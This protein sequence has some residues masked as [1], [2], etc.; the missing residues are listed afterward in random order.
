MKKNAIITA[1]CAILGTLG[2]LEGCGQK[3]NELMNYIDNW[4]G[5]ADPSNCRPPE[6][7]LE[8]TAQFA[9]QPVNE[10]CIVLL[11]DSI[12]DFGEWDK[13]LPGRN[14]LNRGIAGDQIEGMILRLDEIVRHNP[15]KIYLLAGTNNFV[16]H[17]AATSA[18]VL[19]VY[20]KMVALLRSKM[21]C[22]AI[23]LESILPQNPVSSDWTDHYNADVAAMNLCI[24]DLAEKYGC[25]YLD[26]AS[27]LTDSAGN[28][29][30]D[31][32]TDGCHLNDQ[33]FTLWA[34]VLGL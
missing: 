29:R 18:S 20:E 21:P 27:A 2:V 15:S 17:S 16:K 11:G 6:Y 19:P 5:D 34:A 1:A 31:C 22:C 13:I 3:D 10:G 33:G 30:L 8:K 4:Y 28:L 9:A 26:I 14:I 32:T 12:T 23:I 24:K 25:T 7:Y